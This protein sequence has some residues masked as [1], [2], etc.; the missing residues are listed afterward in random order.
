MAENVFWAGYGRLPIVMAVVNRALAPGWTIWVDHQ[1]AMA[2]RDAGWGQI[3]VKNNQEAYDSVI[4]AF[5]IAE[6]HDVYFPFMVCLDG[7][8]LSHVAAKVELLTQEEVDSFLPPFDPLIAMHPSDPY[9]FGTLTAPN[10]Y[11][12][13][14][15]NLQL[16]MHDAKDVITKVNEEWARLTGRDYGGLVEHSGEPDGDLCIVA[17]STLAEEAEVTAEELTKK[18]IRT[19][20]ARVRVFRPF[21]TEEL[22]KILPKYDKVIVIDR[23]V[24]FGHAGP[25]YLEVAATLKEFQPDLPVLRT[26]MGLGGQDIHYSDIV[27]RIEHKLANPREEVF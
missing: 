23:A 15:T 14:R 24:S 19:G 26:V 3:Y 12:E 5:K 4:Q 9:A 8:V 17:T 2:M 22:A 16:A 6:N 11:I 1:D 7:F 10:E 18:G 20:V 25:L 21:P 27:K 13:L